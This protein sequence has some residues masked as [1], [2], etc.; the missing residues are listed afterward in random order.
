MQVRFTYRDFD[1]QI[2]ASTATIHEEET[3]EETLFWAENLATF[4]CGKKVSNAWFWKPIPEA[5]RQLTGGRE[6]VTY[7][8]EP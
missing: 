8:L 2:K 6:I 5:L 1:G 7:T 4:G 3:S